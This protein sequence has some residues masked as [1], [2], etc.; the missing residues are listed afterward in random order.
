MDGEH[1][2]TVAMTTTA[3]DTSYTATHTHMPL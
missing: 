1:I 3:T 2:S